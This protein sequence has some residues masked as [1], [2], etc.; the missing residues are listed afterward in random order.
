LILDDEIEF[1]IIGISSALSDYRLVWE[2]NTY[3]GLSFQKGDDC[4]NI[5]NKNKQLMSYEYYLHEDE[6]DF[7]K[8]FLVKNKQK[9]STLFAQNEKL[10]FFLILRENYAYTVE[11]LTL[12]LRKINGVIA[13]FSFSSSNFEFSEY[14]NN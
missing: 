6:D 12:E 10:D 9:A 11:D 1:P 7:S 2:L 13:V 14:L 3:L 4:F 5:P 8:F